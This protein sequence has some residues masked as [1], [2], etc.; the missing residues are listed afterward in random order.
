MTR[1]ARER[2]AVGAYDVRGLVGEELTD[3]FIF[4]FGWAVARAAQAEWGSEEILIAHDMRETSPRYARLL[5]AGSRQAG[6]Q[7]KNIGMAST[8]Q[9]YFAS[10]EYGLPGFMVTASHNPPE[11]NGIKVCGP[12]A[13]GVSRKD[14]LG[15]ALEL[16]DSA[17][18]CSYGPG[19]A[20][21]V[22]AADTQLGVDE[23]LA[24]RTARGFAERIRSLTGLNRVQG[25]T[26][27]VDAGSGMAGLTVPQVFGSAA[28]L[29]ALNIT[30]RGMYMEPD[31]T[32]PYH[33]ANPLDPANLVDLQKA[34]IAAR[35]ETAEPVIG[36]A[37]DGDADR[38]F[39]VDEN[40]DTVS[41]SAIG[42][43]TAVNEIRRVRAEE[44][45]VVLHNLLTSRSSVQW[46]EK[47]GGTPV[48]TA[49]GHSG[50]K[51]AIRAN[52]AVFAFEHSAHYYFRDFF[53]ADSG[54]LAAGHVLAAVHASGKQLS[55]LAADYAPGPMS[56]EINSRVEDQQAVLE[57]V[58]EAGQRGDFGPVTIDRL[59]GITLDGD[60][61]WINVRTSNTEPLV[62][63][64][65]EA[66]SQERVDEL[67]EAALAIIR[68]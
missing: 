41:A 3:D 63:L 34:V 29:E 36:L 57:A 49:V 38:C 55:E 61:F 52:N 9:L 15:T 19:S 35:A 45:P 50:I 40:G 10:G 30:V 20:D 66:G 16:L 8:D 60:G 48:R 32:F 25:L 64:N 51:Q 46:V 6:L 4:A 43:M 58:A 27:V 67:V 24:Q 42:A 14:L 39:F 37:F 12:G 22:A 5:A 33:P 2:R 65:V 11:Y 44:Q 1:F 7:P 26:I 47:A 62:R 28:E 21:S 53:G 56:G 18:E 54:L 13:S 68:A 59:D 31:G 17:P 23:A